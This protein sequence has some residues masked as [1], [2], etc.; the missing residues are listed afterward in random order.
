MIWA[1]HYQLDKRRGTLLR[2]RSETGEGYCDL[3]PWPEL[4]D[5]PLEKQLD[6]LKMG[7]LTPLTSNALNFS[8]LDSQGRY[9]GVHLLEGLTVPESHFL[10]TELNDV[11]ESLVDQACREGFQTFKVKLGQN[12]KSELAILK[13]LLERHGTK[14]RLDFNGSLSPE[15]RDELIA[16]DL[17]ADAVE[18]CEDPFSAQL[19]PF[20][21]PIA[22]D[23]EKTET[24]EYRIVKPAVDD[25]E[26]IKE[27]KKP[28]VFTS[29][30]GHPLGQVSD[31]Y[32]A[33]ESRCPEVCGLLSHRVYPK[34][35]FS[36]MLS[37]SGPKW[38][39]P[40]GTGFGFDELLKNLEWEMLI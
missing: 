20:P 29:Y 19:S 5:D 21:F 4:G 33:A 36:E 10:L 3:H 24:Y 35:Q 9:S 25:W 1:H 8:R 2:V 7:V 26:M 32:M 12:L 15:K 37:W 38:R 28:V 16:A 40:A 13:P 14:W 6:L 30:L 23:W 34:N 11:S 18:F 27:E 17:Y 22:R 31:A 39:S